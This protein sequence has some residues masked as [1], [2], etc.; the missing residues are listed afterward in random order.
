MQHAFRHVLVYVAILAAQTGTVFAE[1]YTFT[2]T[3]GPFTLPNTTLVTIPINVTGTVGRPYHVVVTLNGLTHTRASDL[4]ITVNF[5]DY[6][7]MLMSDQ[8]D[9]ADLTN[10]TLRFSD[11]ARRTIGSFGAFVGASSIPSGGYRPDNNQEHEGLTFPP[12]SHLG[13][14]RHAPSANGQWN[15]IIADDNTPD[16]GTLASWTLRIF[17][18]TDVHPG[19][20]SCTD[21]PDYDG[22]GRND[23]AVYRQTTGQYLI[24]ASST[25]TQQV[26]N[27]ARVPSFPGDDVPIPADYDGDGVTDMGIF[28]RSTATWYIVRSFAQDVIQLQGGVRSDEPIPT[29]FDHDGLTDLAIFRPSTGEWFW[30]QSSAGAITGRAFASPPSGDVPARRR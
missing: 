3:G 27:F 10:A 8:G 15:L 16:T 4:D 14:F 11:C 9:S 7:S 1:V 17:T 21:V 18:S 30:L 2:S 24:H 12:G 20:T 13:V 25:G 5:T 28:R 26:I 19:A 29:D 22:D 6:G 23:I